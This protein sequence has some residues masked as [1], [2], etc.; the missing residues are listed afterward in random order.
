MKAIW[1]EKE[2]SYLLRHAADHLRQYRDYSEAMRASGR[3]LGISSPIPPDAMIVM[4]DNAGAA[5]D[6]DSRMVPR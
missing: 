6:P 3:G 5:L 2:V 1:T 4:L